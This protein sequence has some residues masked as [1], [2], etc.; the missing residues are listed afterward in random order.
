[1]RLTTARATSEADHCPEDAQRSA[2]DCV[3]TYEPSMG[4]AVNIR[5]PCSDTGREKTTLTRSEIIP[6]LSDLIWGSVDDGLVDEEYAK[7]LVQSLKQHYKL[8][9]RT[10]SR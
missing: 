1:M 9:L 5:I 7:S 8:R 3:G 2:L 4:S 6:I 10:R